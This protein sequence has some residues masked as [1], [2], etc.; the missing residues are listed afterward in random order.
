MAAAP[1]PL[2]C[3]PRPPALLRLCR[4]RLRPSSSAPVVVCAR[5]RRLRSSPAA[6]ACKGGGSGACGSVAVWQCGSVCGNVCSVAA[7]CMGVWRWHGPS[8]PTSAHRV[9]QLARGPTEHQGPAALVGGRAAD[10]M[11]MRDGGVLQLAGCA[12]GAGGGVRAWG[13]LTLFVRL[14][15]NCGRPPPGAV[16]LLYGVELGPPYQTKGGGDS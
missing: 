3:P 9:P 2:C 16:V 12:G 6:H 8:T 10:M 7:M 5:R 4:R 11:G 15:P 14:E 13:Q 1:P